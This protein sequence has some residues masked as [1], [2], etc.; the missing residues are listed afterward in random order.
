MD[1]HKSKRVKH[2]YYQDE[3]GKKGLRLQ[4]DLQGLRRHAICELDAREVRNL[5][6]LKYKIPKF[7]NE[8]PLLINFPLKCNF[9]NL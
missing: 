3:N 6:V 7:S 2:M 9:E 8:W 1:R 5:K 4:F